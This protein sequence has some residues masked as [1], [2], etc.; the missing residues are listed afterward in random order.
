[1]FCKASIVVYAWLN[2]GRDVLSFISASER[3]HRG[4]FQLIFG[5]QAATKCAKDSR[6]YLF[7]PQLQVFLTEVYQSLLL[8]G[9]VVFLVAGA[10][11]VD[12]FHPSVK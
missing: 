12:A 7:H 3:S 2:P 1:M 9:P 8:D 11:C 6:H 10:G 5:C 4:S